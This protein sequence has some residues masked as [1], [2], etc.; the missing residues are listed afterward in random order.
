MLTAGVRPAAAVRATCASTAAQSI[1][2]ATVYGTSTAERP[3][4]RRQGRMRRTTSS[5]VPGPILRVWRRRRGGATTHVEGGG[6]VGAPRR[7]CC[8]E[9]VG[10]AGGTG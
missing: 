2:P 1:S 7:P 6:T 3:S 5:V 8:N 4:I 10:R 9:E